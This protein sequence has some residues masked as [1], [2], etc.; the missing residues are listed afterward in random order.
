MSDTQLQA[1]VYAR[2]AYPAVGVP[3]DAEAVARAARVEARGHAAGYAAGLRAADAVAASRRSEAEAE[4]AARTAEL[5]ER[6]AAGVRTLA[7]AAA[8]FAARATP[9]LDE[10]EGT[11]VDAA[12]QLAEAVVGHEIRASRPS[13]VA[14]S[15]REA[16]PASGAYATVVRALASVDRTVVTALRL[17]PADAA[18]VAADDLGVPVVA[19]A[20]LQDGDAVVD[21]PNG[22]LDA[23]ITTALE[24]ART[25]LLGEDVA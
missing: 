9:V 22:L 13:P 15:G 17:S 19:D 3:A 24:R 23:R 25:A 18:A 1:P 5:E 6:H 11:L 12:L 20:S 14:L 21:L 8:A 4:Y 10:A 7:A 2:I 16:L